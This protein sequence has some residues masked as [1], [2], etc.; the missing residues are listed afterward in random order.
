MK[1]IQKIDLYKID[2]V[3]FE[4]LQRYYDASISNAFADI[5]KK[6]NETFAFHITPISS[7]YARIDDIANE[8]KSN[9][10]EEAYR[11]YVPCMIR[12]CMR[13]VLLYEEAVSCNT[14]GDIKIVHYKKYAAHINRLLHRYSYELDSE[15]PFEYRNNE[16]VVILKYKLSIKDT[17]E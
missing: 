15:E 5:D 12:H 11:K 16:L 14:V 6:V 8:L 3:N 7:S 17:E 13:S 2:N 4:E 9:D 1:N 10:I